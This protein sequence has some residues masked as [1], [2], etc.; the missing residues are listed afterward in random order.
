MKGIKISKEKNLTDILSLLYLHCFALE[1]NKCRIICMQVQT[2]VTGTRYP[3]RHSPDCQFKFL[4]S[5]RP[6]AGKPPTAPMGDGGVLVSGEEDP[7]LE[8]TLAFPLSSSTLLLLLLSR[9]VSSPQ[10]SASPSQSVV[11]AAMV[12]GCRLE[13]SVVA[14][15]S[16]TTCD[17][18]PWS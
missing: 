17:L 3:V 5:G 15:V 11:A 2:L 12:V 18:Q 16:A 14:V 9:L 13:R 4:F 1:L 6:A 7:G 8:P 10:S